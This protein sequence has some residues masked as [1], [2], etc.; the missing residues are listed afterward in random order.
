MEAEMGMWG[1]ENYWKLA[2]RRRLSRRNVLAFSAAGSAAALAAAC[3]TGPKSS[4]P[5]T[6]KSG[7][8]TSAQPQSGGT[9]QY[10]DISNPT[11]DPHTNG[12]YFKMKA[13][14][15]VMSRLLKYK[16]GVDPK[17]ADAHDIEPD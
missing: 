15:G 10:S 2:S 17:V 3:G 11:L 8:Q 16:T 6:S 7:S 4:N 13:V 5:S 9:F 12:R 1:E 14:G